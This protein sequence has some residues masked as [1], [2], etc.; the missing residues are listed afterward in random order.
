MLEGTKEMSQKYKIS[1]L[2]RNN[3]SGW[4]VMLPAIILFAF[5]FGNHC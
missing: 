5:L 4:L 2:I 3:L 1:K